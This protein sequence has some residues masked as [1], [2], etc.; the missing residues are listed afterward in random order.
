M[1]VSKNQA[2]DRNRANMLW[3]C[4]YSPHL[5]GRY[6]IE[7][8]FRS[9]GG[10]AL[11]NSHEDNPI[12]G[13]ALLAI[14]NPCLIKANVPI[15]SL[16]DSY[17]PESSMIRVFLSQRGHRLDNGIE[18]E[19]FSLHDIKPENIVEIVEYPSNRFIELTKCDTWEQA[20]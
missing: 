18:H 15:A 8:F 13:E 11:F 10:E 1:L 4:F 7:R 20:L 17:Y 16:K 6:G 3:F 19:G 14:G 5:A 9:W 12:T 2:D